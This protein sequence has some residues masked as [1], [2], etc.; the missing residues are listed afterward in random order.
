MYACYGKTPGKAVHNPKRYYCARRENFYILV[1]AVCD[2]KRL[3]IRFELSCPLTTHDWLAWNS[4]KR[5]Q[6]I[7]NE[8]LTD[9]F[10][11]SPTTNSRPQGV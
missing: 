3:F 7:A 8:R 2:A 4:I 11:C 1:L 9:P 6:H 5:G 10:F